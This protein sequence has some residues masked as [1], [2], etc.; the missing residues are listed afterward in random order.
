MLAAQSAESPR[1]PALSPKAAARRPLSARRPAR[2][3]AW[4]THRYRAGELPCAGE[5]RGSRRLSENEHAVQLGRC[6]GQ[7]Q[8]SECQGQERLATPSLP[9]PAASLGRLDTSR[10]P[11]ALPARS[12]LTDFPC[13]PIAPTPAASFA[14]HDVGKT[15]RLSGW[16]HRV[17]DHGG[18]LFI[19]LR[20]HYG[21]TQVV[22]DPKSPAFALA[23]TVRAG[24]GDPR[25]TARWWRARPRR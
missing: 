1:R 16:V 9:P 10:R 6:R 8:H 12:A 23:E 24:M 4:V 11:C 13:T 15:V 5:M 17:R 19:D 20:D 7:G 3:I 22:A 2:S 21:M 14:E 18:L 25:S